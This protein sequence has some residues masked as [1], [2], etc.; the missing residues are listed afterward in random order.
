MT[1]QWQATVGYHSPTPVEST[2]SHSHQRVTS[3][4]SEAACSAAVR[5]RP[6]LHAR[7]ATAQQSGWVAPR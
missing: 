4:S 6:T 7:P 2:H 5:R 1:T 3:D